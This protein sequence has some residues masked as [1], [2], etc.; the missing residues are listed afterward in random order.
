MQKCDSAQPTRGGHG[1]CNEQCPGVGC[2][3]KRR[4]DRVV[5]ENPISECSATKSYLAASSTTAFAILC[6]F[7]GHFSFLE[8]LFA[9]TFIE[10]QDDFMSDPIHLLA[11]TC[12]RIY[13][14]RKM[15]CHKHKPCV[16]KVDCGCDQQTLYSVAQVVYVVIT[17]SFDLFIHTIL[18][19]LCGIEPHKT[20]TSIHYRIMQISV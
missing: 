15:L 8:T 10:N 12:Q 20:P 14:T 2:I 4:L 7:V 3:Q 6:S 13:R 5:A 11:R 9:C 19:K 1:E 16:P 17:N 18:P